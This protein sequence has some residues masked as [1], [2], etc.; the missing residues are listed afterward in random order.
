MKRLSLWLAVVVTTL[1]I[2]ALTT[3]AQSTSFQQKRA[4]GTISKGTTVCVGPIPA[5]DASGVQLFGF[6]NGNAALTWQIRT[7][8]SQSAPA[9]IFETTARFVDQ[10]VLPQGNFL[11]DACVTKGPGPAE[12]FDITLNSPPAE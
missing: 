1:G 3:S 10:T 2:G 11:F 7:V 9:V 5:T 12:D 6:T 8:S 4:F